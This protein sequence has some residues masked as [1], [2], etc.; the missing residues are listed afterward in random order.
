[1]YCMSMCTMRICI[2]GPKGKI[3]VHT[4]AISIHIT[5]ADGL[6]RLPVS[7]HVTT[8]PLP[9]DVLLLLQTLQGTPVRADQIHQWTDTDPILSRTCRNVL[10]GWVDS[11]DPELQPYQSQ[12]AELSVQ[13][14]SCFHQR[15]VC[16]I[17]PQQWYPSSDDCPLSPCL[18]WVG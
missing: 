14:R 15:R 4:R 10:S 2:E 3:L 11:D 5:N 13:E 9:G 8:V 1:M 6:S 12:A 18:Q 16:C 17:C 7:N